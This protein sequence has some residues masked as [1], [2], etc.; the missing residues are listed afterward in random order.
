MITLIGRSI[1]AAGCTL[2]I[3]LLMSYLIAPG[4]MPPEPNDNETQISITRKKRDELS[5]EPVTELPAPPLSENTPP[6]LMALSAP[7]AA[8]NNVGFQSLTANTGSNE[9]IG[10]NLLNNQR[11]MPVVYFAP[12]YPQGPL[13]DGIEGWVMLEFTI[14][15]DGSVTDIHVVDAEPQGKFERAAIRTMQRWSY[16]PKLVEGRPVAQT[17]MREIF[18]F[19]IKDK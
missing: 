19:E 6:P 10:G 12:E 11:A 7:A 4:A 9:N 1:I 13:M 5:P 3:F 17:N 8:I 2:G 14:A 18:R 15:S 16:Q